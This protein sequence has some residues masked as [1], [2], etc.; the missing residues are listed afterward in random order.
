[1][2]QVRVARRQRVEGVVAAAQTLQARERVQPQ[3][4]DAPAGMATQGL[5]D[6]ARLSLTLSLS[7][8]LSHTLSLCYRQ[9]NLADDK[10][11]RYQFLR[12]FDAAM[13]GLDQRFQVGFTL[14]LLFN[15]AHTP[16][17]VPLSL[18]LSLSLSLYLSVPDLR[19]GLC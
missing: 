15:F 6:L 4:C 14:L 3:F 11:L 13:Q 8:Y 1:M 19:E 12:D 16:L 10:L 9:F 17:S 5:A 18:S 7:L 2:A